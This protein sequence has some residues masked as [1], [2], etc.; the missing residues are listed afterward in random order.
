MAQVSSNSH[1]G[2]TTDTT[3]NM[4]VGSVVPVA[5]KQV[6]SK[7]IEGSYAGTDT[8]SQARQPQMPP[9]PPPRAA[10]TGKPGDVEEGVGG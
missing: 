6:D 8:R 9:Q 3:T 2:S 4:S 5:V 1:H 7:N 10:S